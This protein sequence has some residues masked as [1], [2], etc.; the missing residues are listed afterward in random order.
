MALPLLYDL[1]LLS[2]PPSAMLLQLPT[3]ATTTFATYR[4]IDEL[5]YTFMLSDALVICRLHMHGSSN[6]TAWPQRC[7][8][9]RVVVYYAE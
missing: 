2:P 1:Q 4:L 7:V 8:C 9:V 6:F 3:L 5:L